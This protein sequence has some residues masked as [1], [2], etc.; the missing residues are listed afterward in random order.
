MPP[1]EDQSAILRQKIRERLESKNGS[2]FSKD[3]AP[4]VLPPKADGPANLFEGAVEDKRVQDAIGLLKAGILEGKKRYQ[5]LQS[6]QGIPGDPRDVGGIGTKAWRRLWGTDLTSPDPI[7]L[8]RGALAMMGGLK[9]AQYG[10]KIPTLPMPFGLAI[11]PLTGGIAGGMVGAGALSVFPETAIDVGESIG[12]FPEGTREQ[13]LLND[14]NLQT[15]AEGEAL[16]DGVMG[17]PLA[18]TKIVGRGISRALTDPGLRGAKLA[19]EAYRYGIEL[20]ITAVGTSQF[21]KFFTNVFGR[22][23]LVAPPLRYMGARAEQKIKQ[24]IENL[25]SRVGP[26][27]AYTDLGRKMYDD[28]RTLVH[29]TSKH[30]NKQYERLWAQ[31]DAA[32][33]TVSPGAIRAR[34][35]TILRQLETATPPKEVTTRKQELV[36]G[37]DFMPSLKETTETKA[38][39]GDAGRILEDL[40]GFIRDDINTLPSD[41]SF[42]QMDGLLVKLDDYLARLDPTQKSSPVGKKVIGLVQS[43]KVA[44]QTD[45]WKHVSGPNPA[46]AR[47]IANQMKEL[48]GAF[49][50]T[51]KTLFETSAAKKFQRVRR[52]GLRGLTPDEATITPVDQLWRVMKPILQSPQGV[53]ELARLLPDETMQAIAARYFDDALENSINV[54]SITGEDAVEG[55]DPNVFKKILGIHRRNTPAGKITEKFLANSSRLSLRELNTVLDAASSLKNTPIPDASTFIARRGSIAGFK[56]ILGSLGVVGG[57]AFA[58]GSYLLVPLVAISG[59]RTISRLLSSPEAARPLRTVLAKN[60]TDTAANKAGI[61]LIRMAVQSAVGAGELEKK[62]AG[63]VYDV[64]KEV[65]EERRHPRFPTPKSPDRRV[66]GAPPFGSIFGVE[67]APPARIPHAPIDVEQMYQRQYEP[68]FTQVNPQRKQSLADVLVRSETPLT[69]L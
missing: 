1:Q 14:Q 64:L 19:E 57:T 9:G 31:A 27:M 44:G 4:D 40:K 5:T 38:V 7:P 29:A 35:N 50:N 17:T 37:P 3:L 34:A 42:R 11:N 49:S 32:G 12:V 53:D 52:T 60:A 20:P 24:I 69:G 41:I 10:A 56:G 63:E 54:K 25:P 43:M 55:F 47:T 28:A 66:P 26:V 30:F 67:Q 6:Q 36:M 45:A 22:F 61:Q 21:A 13:Y 59:L 48:D 2:T 65:W 51:M 15:L 39:S 33:V 62:Y 16:I 23:P 46:A 18:A 8:T 58:S 68:G